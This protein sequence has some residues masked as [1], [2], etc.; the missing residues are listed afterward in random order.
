MMARTVIHPLSP[1]LASVRSHRRVCRLLNALQMW[2]L[3]GYIV[4][5]VLGSVGPLGPMLGLE[6]EV[7]GC[8]FSS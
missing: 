5:M 8:S 7:P 6:I 2:L 4:L 1:Q 3:G